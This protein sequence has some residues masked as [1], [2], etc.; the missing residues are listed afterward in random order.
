MRARTAFGGTSL[1]RTTHFE[2]LVLSDHTLYE[3]NTNPRPTLSSERT[4]QRL[5]K[6]AM[7]EA[8]LLRKMSDTR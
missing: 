1:W 4:L 2:V 8:N 5:P 3:G 6:V 7:Q